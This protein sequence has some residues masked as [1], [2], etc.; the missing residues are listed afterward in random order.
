MAAKKTT[1]K[2]ATDPIE[3][4]VKAVKKTTRKTAAKK[5]AVKKAMVDSAHSPQ[6]ISKETARSIAK[7]TR[8]TERHEPTPDEIASEAFY[9]YERRIADGRPGNPHE[10]WLEAEKILRSRQH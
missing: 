1:K 10:D 4:P 5:T 9:V 3:E 2:I 8:E 6:P 7:A